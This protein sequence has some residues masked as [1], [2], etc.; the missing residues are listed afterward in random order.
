MNK[1][2]MKVLLLSSLLCFLTSRLPGQTAKDVVSRYVSFIGGE[3]AWRKVNTIIA[4]GEYNYGGM[5]F[6]F[7][8]YSKAPD[9]YKLIVPFE[10]KFYAQGF[11]GKSGW[12]IDAFK[13]E[14]TPTLME[15]K[16]AR[17]LANEADVELENA[18]LH[19][20]D[21]GHKISFIRIDT[22]H[23]K[24]C[25]VIKLERKTGE[26]EHYYFETHT[27]EL[28]MKEAT[29]KNVELKGAHLKIYFS[30]YREKDGIKIPFKTVCE[31]DGQTILTITTEEFSVNRSIDNKEF[32]PVR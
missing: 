2:L 14:T 11:D 23:E 21:K 19:Y 12:K 1:T 28:L 29:S 25:E 22:V 27:G 5:P 17:A 10:G 31:S 16:E 9:L 4:S 26:V 8:T 30:D 24:L 13:N 18:F 7:T 3:P 20:A 6:P 32:Q 15:G